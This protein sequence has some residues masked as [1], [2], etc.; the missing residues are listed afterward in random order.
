MGEGF[1][2]ET[3][4]LRRDVA[5]AE[6][7]WEKAEALMADPTVA[8]LVLDELNIALR[9]DYLPLDRVLGAFAARRPGL[10]VVVTGR[11]A[12]P[13][14]GEAADLVPEFALEHWWQQLLHNQTALLIRARL[15]FMPGVMVTSVPYQ[16][17][18]GQAHG[19]RQAAAEQ[20]MKEAHAQRVDRSS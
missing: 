2:W 11:N 8:L 19:R 15:H 18:S 20:Q 7:A 16:L 6:R 1:T 10:H 4:D 13:A 17:G 9:Y 12:K 14:L 5:A 3:Q